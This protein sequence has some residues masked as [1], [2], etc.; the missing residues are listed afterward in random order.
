[1]LRL[2]NKQSPAPGFGITTR[3][4]TGTGE[5]STT[6]AGGVSGRFFSIDMVV[7]V[8]VWGGVLL[9]AEYV[10]DGLSSDLRRPV[11]GVGRYGL[12]SKDD[13]T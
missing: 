3:D 4:S 7:F 8:I 13:W 11:R 2:W 9:G 12:F 6:S 5:C 1:M 10:D